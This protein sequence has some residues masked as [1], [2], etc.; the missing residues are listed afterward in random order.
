MWQAKTIS[1][2]RASVGALRGKIALVPT[3]GALHQGHLS[4]MRSARELA[5]HVVVSIF[6]NPT[7]FG[8]E[9]DFAQY[10]RTLDA[11]LQK[12][13]AAGVT[14]VFLPGVAEIYPENQMSCQ[15]N[16]RGIADTL[17]GVIRPG[18]FSGVCRVVAK[19][20]NIVH[21][22]IACFGQKDLQQLRLIEAMARDLC[23]VTEIIGLP[24]LRESDGLAMSSRHV[25]LSKNQR[26]RAVGLYRALMIGKDMIEKE[27]VFNVQVI[28]KA[29]AQELGVYDLQIDYAVVRDGRNLDLMTLIEPHLTPHLALL[30]AAKLGDV[31]LIDNVLLSL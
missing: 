18:H 2:V 29:M 1:Q 6:V 22:D 8:P 31:R 27:G 15:L 10:P 21:P 12:C 25:Y 11:D 13:Q 26:Q 9:E 7:Q 28:E 16:V 24:T 5:D 3:M 14:G 20:L 30:V 23:M 19:L 4:L 17:E